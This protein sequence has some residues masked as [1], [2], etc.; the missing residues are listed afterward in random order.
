MVRQ[1]APSWPSLRAA[2]PDNTRKKLERESTNPT[3]TALC[4]LCTALFRSLNHGQAARGAPE[5]SLLKAQ[6]QRLTRFL[7]FM[8]LNR[9]RSGRSARCASYRNYMNTVL[10]KTLATGRSWSSKRT[11]I[12]DIKPISCCDNIVSNKRRAKKTA[13]SQS[14]RCRSWLKPTSRR[15]PHPVGRILDLNVCAAA[16]L[17]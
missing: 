16:N 1:S 3:L 9:V 6:G 14:S 12:E 10:S 13:V 7:A 11:E 8:W 15:M 2:L 17:V 4:T 5:V